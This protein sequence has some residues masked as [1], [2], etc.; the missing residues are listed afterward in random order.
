MFNG[1]AFVSLKNSLPLC[2]SALRRKPKQPSI[3]FAKGSLPVEAP[4]VASDLHNSLMV[5]GENMVSPLG[6]RANRQEAKQCS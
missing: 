1:I 6:K 4:L 2:L 5:K 3:S